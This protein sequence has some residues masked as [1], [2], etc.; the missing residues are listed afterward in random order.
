MCCYNIY[1]SPT[2]GTKKVA[3]FLAKGLA[4]RVSD[5]DLTDNQQGIQYPS[6]TAD[7]VVVIAVPSYSGRVPVP[8]VERIA[9]LCGNGAKAILVGVYGNRAY[10]DT[11]VE[12]RDVV[13]KSGFK[14]VAAAAVVAEHSIARRYAAGRP[15]SEDCKQLS[16]FAGKI[17]E[18]LATGLENEPSI[19]GNRPY[20]DAGKV[21]FVPK[22]TRKCKK[23]GVCARKCPVG[24]I[25]SQNYAEVDRDKCISCMRCVAVCPHKSRKISPLM[26]LAANLM[27]RKACSSR[28][29]NE[30]FL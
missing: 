20:R 9:R 16:I 25:D 28:K 13:V 12:L 27:L 1:F 26:L 21:G 30:L 23:C 6:F 18:K 8:A 17:H 19:P 11:L 29:E 22:P 24:A 2:G 4:D 10:E 3:T 14:V 5:I 15:D 7:N